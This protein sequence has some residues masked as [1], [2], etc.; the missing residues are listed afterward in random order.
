MRFLDRATI[1][2]PAE[3]ECRLPIPVE[4]IIILEEARA[5][6][7]GH[8]EPLSCRLLTDRPFADQSGA[9]QRIKV[10]PE[11]LLDLG[12]VSFSVEAPKPLGEDS[13]IVLLEAQIASRCAA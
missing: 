11:L 13:N 1:G 9:Y 3:P 4:P 8:F 5:R 2:R 7:K 6:P 10:L 12:T